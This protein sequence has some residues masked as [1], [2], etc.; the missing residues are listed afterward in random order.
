MLDLFEKFI[1]Y[2]NFR[3]D[4]FFEKY[5]IV[6]GLTRKRLISLTESRIKEM[7]RMYDNLPFDGGNLFYVMHL[8]E[9]QKDYLDINKNK[10]I[11]LNMKEGEYLIYTFLSKY[12]IFKMKYL[13]YLHKSTTQKLSE[14]IEE[15]ERSLN[16]DALME[17]LEKNPSRE[18]EI[19]LIYYY[20]TKFMNIPAGDEYYEKVKVLFDKNKNNFDKTEKINIY[21]TLNTYC[22]VRI[23]ADIRKYE[24]EL[25]ELYLKMLEENLVLGE[26]EKNIHI[27]IFYNVFALALRLGELEWTKSFIEKYHHKLIPEYRDTMYNF[28]YAHYYFS[29]NDFEKALVSINKV[30]FENYYIKTGARILLLKI[31]FELKYTESFFSLCD[32]I[33]H[34]LAHDKQIP[35]NVKKTDHEFIVLANKIF[36]FGLEPDKYN[37]TDIELEIK[38]KISSINK[39]WL[40]EKLNES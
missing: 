13:N 12:L 19:I 38:N 16:I 21:L 31:Y 5:N 24:R 33:K 15:F 37:K 18:A 3:G 30:N 36:R 10:M 27:T 7:D 26:G 25:F 8:L 11:D 22:I 1:G 14:F 9:M 17:N 39:E 20:C 2:L 28:A 4:E 34:Y 29:S 40:L 6:F 32:T 35:E 23:R